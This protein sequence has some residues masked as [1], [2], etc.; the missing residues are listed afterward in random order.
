MK[1][2]R[3]IIT[4]GIIV[5]FCIAALYGFIGSK[6]SQSSRTQAVSGTPASKTNDDAAEKHLKAVMEKS[7]AMPESHLVGIARG[8]DYQAVTRKVVENAGGLSSIIKKGDTVVIKP[9]LI[10]GAPAGSPVCTDYRVIQVMADMVREL[11]AGKVIVAEASPAGN[12]FKQA[13]YDKLTGVE[14]VDMNECRNED[15]YDLKP[16]KS[17]TGKAIK[18]PKIYMDADVVIGAGKLKTHQ[19]HDA[20]VTLGLKLSMGVP[21]SRFYFGGGY[22]S[23]LHDLGLKEV[24]ADLN[25]IRRPDFVVIDGIVAGEGLGPVDV[26]PVKSNIMF[27]GSDLVALDTIALTFMGYTVNE[28]PHVKLASE[29][30]LGISDLSRIQVVGA[31]INAIKTRFKRPFE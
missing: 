8:E 1:K 17:L 29:E 19:M 5:V 16:S 30:G 18:I 22:K 28:V 15:C 6:I 9:N 20:Q 11:G 10:R 26:E 31:D 25:R 3:T 2:F 27:A 7:A 14:L 4:Y 24:I 21:P 23:G 13:E 12:V